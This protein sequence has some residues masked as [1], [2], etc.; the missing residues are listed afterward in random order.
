MRINT[1]INALNVQRNLSSVNVGLSKSIERLSSGLRINRAADDAA[2]LSISEKLRGQS[3]G[4]NQA[5]RNAQDGISMIQTAEGGLN[6]THAILQRMRELAIQGANDTLTDSDRG[7]IVSELSS[8]KSEV[9]R[10]ASNT[11][12]NTKKLLNGSMVTTQNVATPGADLISGEVLSSSGIAVS[13]N[14]SG[15]QAGT[16]YSLS[17]SNSTGVT[18]TAT[19]GVQPSPRRS[20]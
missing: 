14:V 18:I 8:L 11:E 7:A 20:L 5:I 2:G 16:T 6:E 15:A 3:R 10:I 17:N 4:L 1:N 12:F 19:I 9:N 13:V